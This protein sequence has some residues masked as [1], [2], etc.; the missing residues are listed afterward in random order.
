MGRQ[1]VGPP[2]EVEAGRA[3]PGRIRATYCEHAIARG[4][5]RESVEATS[6]FTSFQRV[7]TP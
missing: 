6:L 5:Y 7:W 4:L 2:A 3:K 1:H